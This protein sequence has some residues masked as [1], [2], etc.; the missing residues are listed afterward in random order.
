[1]SCVKQVFVIYFMSQESM[2]FNKN[3]YNRKAIE[4]T[5]KAF[6][7]IAT[8]GL[9]ENEHYYIVKIEKSLPETRSILKDE[10]CNYTLSEMNE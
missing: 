7:K 10:F 1:M 3:I 4:S 8:F 9:S 2:Q 6:R 5:I